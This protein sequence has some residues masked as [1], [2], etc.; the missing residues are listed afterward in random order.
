MTF[1]YGISRDVEQVLHRM[2]Q[3]A[4]LVRD[5]ALLEQLPQRNA[6]TAALLRV[7]LLVLMWSNV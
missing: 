4:D 1:S 7:D 6:E 5:V 2:T 3:R